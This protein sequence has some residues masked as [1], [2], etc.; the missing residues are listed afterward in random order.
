[1]TVMLPNLNYLED[2]PVYDYERIL[3]DAWKEGGK[4]AEEKARD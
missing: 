4:E 1:M 2:R 3:V